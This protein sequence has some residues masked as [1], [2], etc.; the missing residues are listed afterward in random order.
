MINGNEL[1]PKIITPEVIVDQKKVKI[2][3]EPF[4]DKPTLTRNYRRR[5]SIYQSSAIPFYFNG[6]EL[7]STFTCP[8]RK[9]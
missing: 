4:L 2:L 9:A 3:F 6:Y 1:I 5:T 8:L 7:S